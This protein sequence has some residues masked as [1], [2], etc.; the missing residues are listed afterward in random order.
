M[1][2]G[3]LKPAEQCFAYEKNALKSI[4]NDIK[5]GS[6]RRD[7]H[8]SE[9]ELEGTDIELEDYTVV[10]FL[11]TFS[12]DSLMEYK[13][14]L[15]KNGHSPANITNA[16]NSKGYTV[17]PFVLKMSKADA[18]KAYGLTDEQIDEAHKKGEDLYI[19]ESESKLL[20]K[21]LSDNLHVQHSTH[22]EKKYQMPTFVQDKVHL[23]GKEIHVHGYISLHALTKTDLTSG[24]DLSKGSK[25]TEFVNE[26]NEAL[27]QYAQAK[28][29]SY[30]P[31]YEDRAQ[32]NNHNATRKA[33]LSDVR[34]DENGSNIQELM[35][36]SQSLVSAYN[37]S[38]SE[39]NELKQE[40]LQAE[41]RK[42]VLEQAMN[43]IDVH[44]KLVEERDSLIAEKAQIEVEK[45]NLI[46]EVEQV[47]VQNDSLQNSIEQYTAQLTK[48]QSQVENLTEQVS[49]L[50]TEKT[51]LES[52]VEEL[53][54]EVKLKDETIST[55]STQL[56][57]ANSEIEDLKS[58]LADQKLY[59]KNAEDAA[60]EA[61]EAQAQAETKFNEV[62]LSL[63]N[64]DNQIDALKAEL[65]AER[66]A[67]QQ[68]I[69]Q[70][71]SEQIKQMQEMQNQFMQQMQQ[72]MMQQSSKPKPKPTPEPTEEPKKEPEVKKLF[73]A[74]DEDL[75]LDVA[76]D[77]DDVYAMVAAITSASDKKY[78]ESTS[79]HFLT[80]DKS[81]DQLSF[82]KDE[83]DEL[84]LYVDKNT[85]EVVIKESLLETGDGEWFAKNIV[86][87]LIESAKNLSRD[88][89]FKTKNA[90][91]ELVTQG[92]KGGKG[93]G[94]ET[95]K[96]D[97]SH[98]TS[99]DFDDGMK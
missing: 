55:V 96:D 29:I 18:I 83:T 70:M 19:P 76:D 12:K 66:K 85:K 44:D 91:Y 5:S 81:A 51:E 98:N 88:V 95:S 56:N 74:D 45:D 57:S 48:S 42:N 24:R 15:Q 20:A 36:S 65:D 34:I 28:D 58:E 33:I 92:D 54:S 49:D 93:T 89:I 21:T 23:D 30:I 67:H 80:V 26:F 82:Y 10:E 94:T 97:M 60:R 78:F 8:E 77:I 75:V 4:V 90:F 37:D 52:E 7:S 11:E 62:Q 99:T 79:A 6:G 86:K 61:L 13:A 25:R 38:I 17:V 72:M 39:L 2:S 59:L 1:K 16:Q 87:G 9:G 31:S 14:E 35:T 68:A 3:F 63:T 43:A 53:E 50:S 71:Q 84:V 64:K 41:M 73:V 69:A 40:Y 27:E 47:S 32:Q 22:N 46:L